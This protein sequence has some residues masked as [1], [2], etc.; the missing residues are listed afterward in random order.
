L[1]PTRLGI[2]IS[3]AVRARYKDRKCRV[4]RNLQN[5]L[6]ALSASKTASREF[7]GMVDTKFNFTTILRHFTRDRVF[8]FSATLCISISL[9]D[10]SCRNI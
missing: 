5:Y 6:R 2:Y 8:R 7:L 1:A 4:L 3:G 10:I 9:R